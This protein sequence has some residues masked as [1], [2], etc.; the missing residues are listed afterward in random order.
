MYLCNVYFVNNAHSYSEGIQ[1]ARD[2]QV[3]FVA[4]KALKSVK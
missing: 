2:T 4:E 1:G 3:A